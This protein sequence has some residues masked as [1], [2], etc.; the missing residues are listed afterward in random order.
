M[1]ASGKTFRIYSSFIALVTL[2]PTGSLTAS[3]QIEV[4]YRDFSYPEGTGSNSK[5]TGEK[6]ESKL[7][8]NDGVWWG[9]LWSTPKNAYCIHW[10]NRST[11]NWLDTGTVVD[12]RSKSR[13][14]VGW[15]GTHLY[16]ASHI[17]AGTGAPVTKASD[18]GKLYRFSYN[19]RTKTHTLDAGFPVDVTN[20]KSETLV[21][22]KDTRGQLWVTYVESNRVMV[23]H[24]VGGNDRIWATP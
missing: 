1:Q 23:N 6:P 21:L 22:A 2:L 16:V 8:F 7:W 19:V 18:R 15:D 12:P 5:P 24:S 4:G 17:F 11:Q 20:G 10:L 13:A 3:E 14:D 9:I